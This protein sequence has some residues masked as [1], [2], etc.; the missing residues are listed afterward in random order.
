MDLDRLFRNECPRVLA[1]L[2]RI[3][4][5]LDRAEDA[6]QE[7]F[8]VAMQRWPREGVPE[9]P[10]AWL[11]STARHK[12]IDAIRRDSRLAP[13]VELEAPEEP[14]RLEVVDDDA[15]RLVFLCCHPDL[16]LD[17]QV[18]MTLREVCGLTT[19]EIAKGFLLSPTTVA[20]RIVRAKAKFRENHIPFELPSKADL[21]QRLQAVLRVAYL[22]F[23][24]GYYASSGYS[25]M[26]LPLTGDAIR[27][28]R[29][30]AE[31]LPDGE[32][33]GLLA[34]MLL[35]ESRR[36]ARVD[37]QGDLVLIA[38]Q[39][40]SRWDKG[41]IEEGLSLSKRAMKAGAGFYSLQAAIAAVHAQSPS[42]QETDWPRIVGLYDRLLKLA[43]SPVV[44]LNRSVA[45]AMCEGPEAGLRIVDGLITAGNLGN[46]G[47]AHSTRADYCRRLGRVGEARVSY[48]RALELATQDRERR[49]L[50]RRLD[51]LAASPS[52]S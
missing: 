4:G 12:A 45:V 16:P 13:I 15:L 23:N 6:A 34:L 41:L 11:I 22:V 27:L 18:A 17:S 42:S 20:Q 10:R 2:V 38:D 51:E 33:L 3:T 1:S 43:P 32:A 44:E 7:A 14:P 26:R 52:E 31:F 37:E 5:N 50:M 8:A 40:R 19:E 9:N 28:A 24:E 49:F 29:L 30:L 47:L 36:A 35:H 25:L 39:D 21:P 46:Y 48:E